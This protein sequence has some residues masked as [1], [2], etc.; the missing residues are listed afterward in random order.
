MIVDKHHIIAAG[1]ILPV[2]K[3]M[4]LPK[5]FG[6]RHRSA[7]GVTEVTDAV[8]IV[9][10]EETGGITVFEHGNLQHIED[11]QELYK[12]LKTI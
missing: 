4:T 6:L 3:D 10:S 11:S 12:Y 1:C 7:M 5:T 2:S 8:S 9:V